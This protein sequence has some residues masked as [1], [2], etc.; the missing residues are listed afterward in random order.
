E[1]SRAGEV[2]DQP[3]SVRNG[4]SLP[5]NKCIDC[6][7]GNREEHRRSHALDH[8]QPLGA[9]SYEPDQNQTKEPG[10]RSRP[11]EEIRK[12]EYGEEHARGKRGAP[13]LPVWFDEG[14]PGKDDKAEKDR[15]GEC[16]HVS[17]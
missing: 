9:T 10:K 14:P 11:Q 1:G 4:V 12:D 17:S 3:S 16:M 2:Q 13:C 8:Q 7:R 5:E 15:E 6:Q